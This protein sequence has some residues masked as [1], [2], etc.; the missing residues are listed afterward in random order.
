MNTILMLSF[1][2]TTCL[3]VAILLYSLDIYLLKKRV[4]RL[5]RLQK[6]DKQNSLSGIL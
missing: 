1:L 5:E 3:G 2:S 6:Q 4:A